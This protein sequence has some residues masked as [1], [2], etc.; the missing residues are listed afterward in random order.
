LQPQC[1]LAPS[2]QKMMRRGRHQSAYASRR[3]TAKSSGRI[4]LSATTAPAPHRRCFLAGTD[5]RVGHVSL[6][7]SPTNNTGQAHCQMK[8][9]RRGSRLGLE[10]ARRP[11]GV[12]VWFAGTSYPQA[13]LLRRPLSPPNSMRA[14]EPRRG[15]SHGGVP[16]SRSILE[17]PDACIKS[18]NR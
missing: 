12:P 14:K 8:P 10:P 17:A 16:V 6:G 2:V 9:A 3:S 18:P 15:L 1:G 4:H 11:G 5:G 7:P 13:A